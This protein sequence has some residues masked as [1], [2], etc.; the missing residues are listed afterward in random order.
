MITQDILK[1]LSIQTESKIVLL[2]ADGVGDLPSK[3]GKTALEF[4]NTPNLDKLAALSVCGLTDPIG[5]GITPGSGPAHLS[6]F[7]YD[8][9]QCQIGRG[10]LEALGID[11]ELTEDD[12]AC[13]GNFATIEKDRII[14]DRRAGRIPT[15]TNKK[16]CSLLQENITEIEGVQVIIKPGKEHRFVVIFRGK[17]LQDGITDADP[18]LN[19]K[20]MKY[21]EALRV[22]SEESVKIVNRFIDKALEVLKDEHPANAILLRGIAKH[23]GLPSMVELFKLNPAAIATYPM[24]RGLAKLVGMAVLKTGETIADEFETLENNF[25][26]YNFFYV[27]IKKTDSY[28][29]DGNFDAKVKIIEELDSFIPQLSELNPDVIAI[30]GD[31]STPAALAA[32]SWHPN[33]FLLHSKFIRVDETRHFSEN[34]C[35]KGGLG[36]FPAKEAIQLMLANALKLKK[37]GA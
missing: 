10:V 30:T 32:H 37:Y 12:L 26:K 7:G 9:I 3:E 21:A 20:K 31:H 28:G 22:Q 17:G 35:V 14:T 19:G 24:Y 2:V 23:P 33:P 8:P 29:E 5:R 13:R 27:H 6:L 34:E 15:E 1:E 4:A 18:Q 36:R 25:Q 16:L 11:V